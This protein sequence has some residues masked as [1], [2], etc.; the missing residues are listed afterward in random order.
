MSL[1]ISAAVGF[2]MR[3]VAG[4]SGVV[5]TSILAPGVETI[6]LQPGT[7]EFGVEIRLAGTSVAVGVVRSVGLGSGA[8]EADRN[9]AARAKVVSALA[10]NDDESD[11]NLPSLDA[12]PLDI[13]SLSYQIPVPEVFKNG[14]W[15]FPEEFQCKEGM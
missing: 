11:D 9:T 15:E 3:F 10:D 5:G 8:P 7:A 12:S 13:N 4:E 14:K 2:G 6:G 1:G